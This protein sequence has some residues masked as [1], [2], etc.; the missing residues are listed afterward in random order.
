[1]SELTNRLRKILD[2]LAEGLVERDV[3]VRLALL[4]ALAGE[5]LL[6]VGPPGTAKSL[7]ARRLRLAFE[8]AT[9]FE[10]LLTRFSVPE[11]LF[12][13]LSIKRLE[14]DRYERLTESYLPTAS[15]AFLDEIFKANSA[16]LNAL[17]TLLNEREFDN[18]SRREKTPLVAVVGAS[19]E[20]PEGDELDALFDRFLLRLHVAPVSARAFPT[21]LHLKDEEIP[22]LPK[23]IGLTTDFLR[24]VRQGAESVEMHDNV[25]ALLGDLRDRC[26]AEKIPVSD[27]R[28]RKIV[29]L[30]RTSAFSNGRDSVSIWDC[31]LLQ[32]CLWSKADDRKKIY[33]WYAERVGAVAEEPSKIH[34][35]ASAWEDKAKRDM[36]EKS[37]KRDDE[38]NHLYLD[39]LGREFTNDMHR[40]MGNMGKR[41]PA[42]EQ[43]KHKTAYID[44]CVGE[45]QSHMSTAKH[46]KED[47]IQQIKSCDADIRNHL[48]L[49]DDFASTASR[50]LNKLRADIDQIIERLTQVV[51][52][53]KQL[54]QENSTSTRIG[55]SERPETG[56]GN[57]LP[58]KPSRLNT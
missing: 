9:Y 58:R 2:T 44:E 53:Y 33:D 22:I 47:I 25:T 27:R 26:A 16:I 51:D 37:Q 41:T 24:A 4:A 49:T 36:S 15:I 13:P 52:N 1:M 18:G 6:L 46:Y 28:W 21:L 17:L 32:H 54:P 40:Y 43:T 35:I 39:E 42:L 29:K 19:N 5:H 10:R 14:E 7:V 3:A 11:E 20:L 57:S 12:G 48:W 45:I 23:E 55:Q 38:G 56:A 34:L 30:L 50:N 31:W 8:G